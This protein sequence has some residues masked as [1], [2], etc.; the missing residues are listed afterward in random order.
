MNNLSELIDFNPEV[1]IHLAAAFERS[2][3][4]PEFWGVNWH[5]NMLVSH[6]VVDT[7]W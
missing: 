4:T 2:E 5:D 6:N 3:E 7:L 1:I